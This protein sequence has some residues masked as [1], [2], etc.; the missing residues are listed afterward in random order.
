MNKVIIDTHFN[1]R[2]DTKRDDPD[3]DSWKLY[4]YH[5][6]L[7][8]KVLP[9]NEKLDLEVI[10]HHG[11]LLLKNN[12]H[13]NFSSDKMFPH[14]VGKYN[15]KFDG[16][17][18]DSETNELKYIVRTIGG[19]I[20]FPAHK[21]NGNTINQVRGCNIQIC[22][23]FDLTLECLR[24][25]YLNEQNPLFGVFLR[26]KG[27]FDLFSCFRSYVDYFL[28]QDFIDKKDKVNFVLPF[29]NF[30]RSALPVSAEEYKSFKDRIVALINNRNKRISKLNL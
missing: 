16:W 11:R 10:R 14:L 15:N 20:I 8:T 19:H 4:E 30:S 5:K 23:R 28:L 27:F 2:N 9:C 18:T 12:L 29:D 1:F 7:W 24:L 26:Y 3:R 17:L 22:D 13:G 21:H 25:F 6:L